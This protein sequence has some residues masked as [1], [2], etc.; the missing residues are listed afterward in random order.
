MVRWRSGA[1]WLGGLTVAGVA[2]YQAVPLVVGHLSGSHPLGHR[3]LLSHGGARLAR[4]LDGRRD[5][6]VDAAAELA[7]GAATTESARSGTPRRPRAGLDAASGASARHDPSTD[8]LLAGTVAPE[9]K[10]ERP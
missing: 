9:A 4:S 2:S 5:V 8:R 1:L 7:M 10:G 3:H 6:A